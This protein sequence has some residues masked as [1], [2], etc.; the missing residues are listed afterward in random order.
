MQSISVSQVSTFQAC[1]KKWQL[2]YVEG[3]EPKEQDT[4]PTTLGTMFHLGMATALK[5][6]FYGATAEEAL[7]S[8][9]EAIADWAV[10]NEPAA[11]TVNVFDMDTNTFNAQSDEQFYTTWALMCVT[12]TE[13]V[14]RTW[15]N[16]D[17]DQR[18]SVVAY[19]GE[20]MVE[21]RLEHRF[22]NMTFVGLVDAVL[23]NKH[24]GL[25]EVIDWKTRKNFTET[26]DEDL[27][28]QTALYQYIL[29]KE[30]DVEVAV[31]TIIQVK[32]ELPRSPKLN[33]D[34][35][36]SRQLITSDWATYRQA[37]YAVGLNEDDYLDMIPKLNSVEF[38]KET[39]VVRN[40]ATLYTFWI[41]F[42]LHV[43]R[44]VAAEA[45]NDFPAA[46]GYACKF[47]QFRRLCEGE[48][49]G[50]DLESI[51][52]TEYSRRK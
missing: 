15:D 31:S 47:C 21:W 32:S 24:T 51:I 44:L 8:A 12:A 10:D 46:Y 49:H 13:L 11:K 2:Q 34:G 48:L 3:L 33:K 41:N 5:A 50:Y 38:F 18:Y 25:T 37:L 43:K 27:N 40:S 29:Y 39:S 23:F 45:S 1:S 42:L 36:M 6:F 9:T 17:I 19:N 20:P 22:A 7:Q 26:L 14:R 28:M 52:D 4:A 16:Y 35:S 30:Y